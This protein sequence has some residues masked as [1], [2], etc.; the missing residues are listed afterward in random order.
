MTLR[1]HLTAAKAALAAAG[2]EPAEAAR[3]VL[4]LAR[5]VLG[6]D[7]ATIHSR[8]SDPRAIRA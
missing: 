7:R 5:H 3:D 8:D 4:L 2:I 1:Q 6:W